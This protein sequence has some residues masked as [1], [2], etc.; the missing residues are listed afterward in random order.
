MSGAAR[1][2]LIALAA[3]IALWP[4]AAPAQVPTQDE[5]AWHGHMSAAMRAHRQQN[6]GA[7][8]RNLRVALGIAESFGPDDGRLAETLLALSTVRFEQ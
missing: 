2:C 3:C 4:A 6:H 8:E 1:R 7:A 5:A